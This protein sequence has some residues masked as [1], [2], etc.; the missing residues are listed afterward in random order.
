MLI[1]DL[2]L[3]KLSP[4]NKTLF[5]DMKRS[6]VDMTSRYTQPAWKEALA[7]ASLLVQLWRLVRVLQL[8]T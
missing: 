4:L 7:T 5:K 2:Y 6:R 3:G 1:L 8:P